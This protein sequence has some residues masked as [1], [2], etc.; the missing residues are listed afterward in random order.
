[1]KI[2]IILASAIVAIAI[3]VSPLVVER[4]AVSNSRFQFLRFDELDD[5]SG[6]R[7]FLMLNTTTGE[8]HLCSS[9]ISDMGARTMCNPRRT[10][11]FGRQL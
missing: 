10:G 8:L 7:W 4:F 6:L 9:L 1:M 11:A 3:V 2:S 5:P